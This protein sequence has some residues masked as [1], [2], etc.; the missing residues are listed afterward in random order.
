M[1]L[2]FPTQLFWPNKLVQE[3]KNSPIVIVEHPVYFTMYK[4]HKMK[5]VLHRAT[6]KCY[7]EKLKNLN[8]NVKYV[9]FNKYSKLKLLLKKENV[10]CYYP[11]DHLVISDIKNECENIKMYES[12]LFLT[13]VTDLKWFNKKYPKAKHSTFYSWQKSKLSENINSKYFEKAKMFQMV[14]SQD[15]YNRNPFPKNISE[16]QQFKINNSIYVKNAIAYVNVNFSKN[17]GKSFL[18]LPITHEKT[19]LMAKKFLKL[20]LPNFGKYQDAV[21]S[22]VNYGFHSVLSPL[23]NIGLITPEQMLELF[24]ENVSEKS[25]IQSAEGYLRQLIGWREYTRYHYIFNR[26]KMEQNI[27]NHKKN[28]NNNYWYYSPENSKMPKVIIDMIRKTIDNAYLHHIERLMYI[29]NYL[30]LNEIHPKHVFVWFQSMF[31]D[32]YHV[33][34]YSNVYGMSQ[35]SCGPLIMT[36]PYFSSSNY[37]KKMSDYKVDYDW[38]VLYRKFVIKNKNMLLKNYATAIQVKNVLRKK[39]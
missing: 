15:K 39:N 9:D 21:S 23:M 33:F 18:Y 2:I 20:F 36:R 5:L 13:S 12:P 24:F 11:D 17:P 26:K 37:I 22:K 27:F 32:S 35:Y 25:N 7:Y 31:L 1:I 3:N 16:V 14:K 8:F 34:M 30:L 38:N 6:M 19:K 10:K 28:I 4:Y 29:G